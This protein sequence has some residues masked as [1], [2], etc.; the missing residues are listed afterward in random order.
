MGK[1]SIWMGS[2][3]VAGLAGEWIWDRAID[4]EW[5]AQSQF[6]ADLAYAW[7]IISAG[8]LSLLWS[9]RSGADRG[10]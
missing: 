2:A 6:V 8:L 5:E 9:L 7:L 10:L 1:L 3:A 4:G